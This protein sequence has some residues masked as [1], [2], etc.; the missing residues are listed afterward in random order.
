MTKIMK[1]IKFMESTKFMESMKRP[2]NLECMKQQKNDTTL[3]HPLKVG[4]V[5]SGLGFYYSIFSMSL[6]STVEARTECV[7]L[8]SALLLSEAVSPRDSLVV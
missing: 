1:S 8:L 5:K 4:L 6:T 2:K 3:S 7:G